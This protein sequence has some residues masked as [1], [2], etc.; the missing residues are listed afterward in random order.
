ME[1][2]STTLRGSILFFKLLFFPFFDFQ[3]LCC[4]LFFDLVIVFETCII[5]GNWEARPVFKFDSKVRSKPWHF[6]EVNPRVTNN[7]WNQD[8]SRNIFFFLFFLLRACIFNLWIFEYIKCE[9]LIFIKDRIDHEP[10]IFIWILKEKA[11]FSFIINMCLVVISF[12]NWFL[13]RYQFANVNCCC[14]RTWL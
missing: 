8:M 2:L 12:L 4:P 3:F 1:T 11:L 7:F 9:P 5:W 10:V 14:V 13:W 6:V